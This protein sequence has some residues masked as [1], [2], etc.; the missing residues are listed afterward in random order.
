M[1]S[2]MSILEKLKVK[3]IAKKKEDVSIEIKIFDKTKDKLV[4][5]DVFLS[6][7]STALKTQKKK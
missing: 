7:I 2:K 5:R 1:S 4:N 6:K 3:P